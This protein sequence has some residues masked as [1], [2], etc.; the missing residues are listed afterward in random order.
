MFGGDCPACPLDQPC[1]ID[2]DC[3]SAHCIRNLCTVINCT[4][5]K[6][7]GHETDIDCGGSDCPRCAATQVCGA[8]GDCVTGVCTTLR[9]VSQRTCGEVKALAATSPDG[10][11]TIDP[12]GAAAGVAFPA[13][14]DMT[15]ASGG[16]TRV[17]FEPAG[18]GG[19]QINGALNHL[20]VSVGTPANVA[21]KTAAG[22]IGSRFNGLYTEVRITWGTN[23]A[24]M[25]VANLFVDT[26]QPSIPV[27]K[28]TTSNTTLTGWLSG[29]AAFCRA[30]SSTFRP[31][32]TSWALVPSNNPDTTCG[33]NGMNWSGNGI[34]YGGANP[35]DVCTGWAGAFAGIRAVG[36]QK[37]GVASTTE[38]VLWVR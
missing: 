2:G 10:L 6:L 9:C 13:F 7:N 18:A 23:Y 17:G 21:N 29:G 16:W 25:T 26:A 30:A 15:S 3:Q 8:H 33:C 4:D 22:L 31:G 5:G 32:D 36:E 28:V 11:Y 1:V 34:Y 19:S 27:S 35:A 20:G 38:L 37:G 24:Q 14:C 12:D